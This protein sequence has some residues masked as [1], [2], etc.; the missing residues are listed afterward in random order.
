[1]RRSG[2]GCRVG[3]WL[4]IETFLF[5]FVLFLIAIGVFLDP[6]LFSF[7]LSLALISALLLRQAF[8]NIEKSF[9]LFFF[10]IFLILGT[11]FKYFLNRLAGV[12]FIETVG[13]FRYS[14]ESW[15]EVLICL[16]VG[17]LSLTMIHIF[18]KN[19]NFKFNT[20]NSLSIKKSIFLNFKLKFKFKFKFNTLFILLF[21]FSVMISLINYIFGIHR[22]GLTPDTIW[23]WPANALIAFAV[24]I[25][26]CLG[27]LL[28]LDADLKVKKRPST[29]FLIVTIICLGIISFSTLSRSILL[30]QI[31]PIIMVILY[32]QRIEILKVRYSILPVCFLGLLI[33]SIMITSQQRRDMYLGGESN[34]STENQKILGRIEILEGGIAQLESF[35]ADGQGD[36]I[37]LEQLKQEKSILEEKI[38]NSSG[39]QKDT[40]DLSFRLRLSQ[41]NLTY[42]EFVKTIE[43]MFQLTL[44]RFIGIEGIMSVQ[45]FDGKSPVFF[46]NALKEKRSLDKDTIY[47]FVAKSN[48][49]FTDKNKWQYATMPGL[50]GFLYMSDSLVIIFCGVALLVALFFLYERLILK[51]SDGAM[52]TTSMVSCYYAISLA[53]IGLAPRSLII[54]LILIPV[55][56]YLGRK[57]IEQHAVIEM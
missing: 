30:F 9:F 4:N 43:T 33:L 36:T 48:Y 50:I 52:F 42:E 10:T 15:R 26:L 51:L 8:L 23:P 24:N 44:S 12:G 35:V 56:I 34:N 46:L 49:R 18:V 57:I 31:A 27:F 11:T 3:K 38:K 25:G 6:N 16:L 14:A 2:A 5:V 21:L 40:K 22:V 7:E 55:C 13:D 47:Q 53:Q 39:E 32:N 28:L 41:I 45:S 29:K 17:L 19:C 37:Y 1:M 20:T 54:Y